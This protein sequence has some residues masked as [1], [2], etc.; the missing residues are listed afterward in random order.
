LTIPL[1]EVHN[2]ATVES[3][4]PRPRLLGQILVGDRV[5]TPEIL[6]EALL[7]AVRDRRRLGEAL[8]AMGTTT[9]TDVLRALAV[10][11]QMA[12][13]AADELPSSPPVLKELSPKYLRQYVACP[14]AVEGATVTVAT[15]EPT[16]PELLD[17]LQQTLGLSVKLC[18][19]PAPAILEAIERAYGANT[20][21]QKIVERMGAA[22][23]ESQ[24]EAEQDVNH[25]RDMAFEAPV[26]RL[27]NLLIDGALAAEA[28]DIHIEPFEDSLRVRYRID[29]LLYDQEAPP[30]RLQ[31]ALTSRIKIMAEMNIA[32]RRLP[33]DGRIRVTA[34]GGRRV[35]IRVSTVPTIHGESIVM[36][37][38]D[39]SSVF[40]PFDRLGF[41][42][43]TAAT[44]E[45]LIHRPHGI[46]LVTG[47]TGS[48]KTTT[49][50]AALDK[51]NRPDLKIL[52]V[53][54]PVE[55]QLKGVNQ[56]PVRPKIGLSFAAGLRH[57]VR[58]DPDVIMVGE[59]RD[60][61][62]AEIAIQSALTG[63]LVFS[64][65][66]TNDA[67]GAV[68][69]L[70]DLGCEPYLVSSVLTGV[71]A[72]RLV[73]RICAACRGHD[74]P[75][76]AELLAI[77]VTDAA[78]VELYRGKGCDECRGTGYRGRTGIYE[79]F[80]VTDEARSL[81]VRRAPAGEIRHHAVEH[82]M[83]TLREDAWAKACAGLT[84]VEEILRVTQ[85]DA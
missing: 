4:A 5:I 48:G 33:Q 40:L 14:I 24:A 75:D 38:L 29:G 56:I 71:L 19:A 41:A 81:I 80:R 34:Q 18:V 63:H 68:T 45:A 12:F 51:I 16:R 3:T 35:D 42:P 30:R 54:D 50:Y 55:Y 17:D 83:V 64:T 69:R 2:P 70:Q 20:A 36:R 28:S 22:P 84:T 9:T 13:L 31:A 59:I 77:G 61:E 65:L 53:E 15:A 27:V 52:T 10:Q 25:L 58:Q 47:P 39:R 26:V 11:Q 8:V 57:I 21:L 67:P 82:G 32:E 74:H 46:L 1:R 44:F 23:A 6:K 43:A 49:L 76:P 79:L 7:R 78:G 62:T 66:H 37:L 60:L 73:R 85:E 72:Q